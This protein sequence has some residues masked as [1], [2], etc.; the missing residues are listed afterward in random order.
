MYY[1]LYI[2]SVFMMQLILNLY[3][4]SLAGKVLR[5]TATHVRLW[6]GAFLGA[7]LFCMILI[8]P[9]GSVSLR[10]LLGAVPVSMC[11]MYVTFHIKLRLLFRSSLVMAGCGFFIGNIMIWFLNRFRI[12]VNRSAGMVG[13]LF[14][15]YLGYVVCTFLVSRLQRRQEKTERIVR[16]PVL[17]N[18]EKVQIMALLDTG[19]HLVDPVSGAP[20]CIISQKLADRL[21]P[22]LVPEKYHVIPYTSVGKKRGILP[23]YEIPVL[24]I[25]EPYQELKKEN[26]MIAV[27]DTGIS[28]DS[29]YQMI[30]NPRLLKTR[31]K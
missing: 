6:L 23:G 24:Y 28:A 17:D 4:L 2:D 7:L 12:S 31:R 18:R 20:V 14:L 9:I 5:C 3:L 10:V 30:L 8:L 27:C 16:I 21:Q 13:T 29:P 25:E 26:V 22:C 1:K 11:M 19:N 15:G